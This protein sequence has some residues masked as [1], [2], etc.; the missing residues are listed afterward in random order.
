M[1]DMPLGPGWPEILSYIEGKTL[2]TEPA[3]SSSRYR[4]AWRIAAAITLLL[5]LSFFVPWRPY[6]VAS[7]GVDDSWML[8]LNALFARHLRMGHDIVFTYGPWGFLHTGVY[9]PDT[10]ALMVGGWVL[11]ATAFWA[12]CWTIGRR[13]ISNP[14]LMLIWMPASLGIAAFSVSH[15]SATL[16]CVIA[17]LLAFHFDEQARVWSPTAILLS[18]SAALASL[19]KFTYLAVACIVIVPITIHQIRRKRFPSALVLFAA[20]FLLFDLL[21]G[22]RLSDLPEFLRTSIVISGGYTDAMSFE[23]TSVSGASILPSRDLLE[24]L[25]ATGVLAFAVVVAVWK[26]GRIA[27]LLWLIGLGGV[28]FTD[29][30]WGFVRHDGMHAPVAASV[31]LFVAL[32]C[33]ASLWPIGNRGLAPWTLSLALAA[34]LVGAWNAPIAATGQ[35]IPQFFVDELMGNVLP[36]IAAAGRLASGRSHYFEQYER[37]LAQIRCDTPA[38]AVRGSVDVYPWSASIAI[39]GGMNY[40]PRPVI[41]SYSA[42]TD[43]LAELNAAHLRGPAAPNNVLLGISD[44]VFSLERF[45]TAD[46]GPSWPELLTRYDISQSNRY[47]LLLRRSNFPRVYQFVPLESIATRLNDQIPVPAAEQGAIWVQIQIE[48]SKSRKLLSTLFKASELHLTVYRRDGRTRDYRLCAASAKSG[49]LLSPVLNDIKAYATFMH[50]GPL[51]ENQVTA[52]RLSEAGCEGAGGSYRP[53]ISV[54]FSR[55]TILAH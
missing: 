3:P 1:S 38:P 25:A 14:A 43:E 37:A 9:H 6:F 2:N 18:A 49:F 41:Q 10:Y 45:P 20:F 36:N 53:D 30:K 21:A 15:Q 50:H 55:L 13:R 26:R 51:I 33:A 28:L 4:N 44:G 39:A 27:A 7:A 5:S 35:R 47:F 52:I 31:L 12:G 40:Q 54:C 22:Q 42:Y 32:L 46:D 48:P 17:L 34:A 23:G 8:A 29:F 16:L 19:T 24:F 11:F